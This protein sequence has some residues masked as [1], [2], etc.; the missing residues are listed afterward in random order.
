VDPVPDPLLF[1]FGSAG[2]RTRAS[3]SVAKN[4]DHYT[5]EAVHSR[6]KQNVN[7]SFSTFESSRLETAGE[8]AQEC[9]LNGN[10]RLPG[11]ACSCFLPAELL[12]PTHECTSRTREG[13]D[14][15]EDQIVY[16]FR[17]NQ[18]E[19]KGSQQK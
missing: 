16:I 19:K 2:N 4:S 6:I 8:T 1:F 5:A 14:V 9:E 17:V 7:C 13:T 11:L 15:S 18:G 3:G 12:L 10:H